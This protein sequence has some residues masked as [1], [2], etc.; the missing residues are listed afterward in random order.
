MLHRV[1]PAPQAFS[2]HTYAPSRPTA[3]FG[4]WQNCICEDHCGSKRWD[5]SAPESETKCYEGDAAALIEFG[6]DA[7][8][9]DGCGAQLNLDLWANLFN[10]SGKHIMIENCHW[11]R[12]VPNA[13]WCPF[14]MYRTSGDVRASYGSV[15]LNL[16]TT[17]KFAKAGNSR[18]GCWAYPDSACLASARPSAHP[19]PRSISCSFGSSPC[20]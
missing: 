5:P 11:G 7:V 20:P 16:Q 8:K 3:L 2:H 13:T 14:N 18:P 15:L 9:L 4:C 1:P 12:T 6:F 19:A 17:V 10:A